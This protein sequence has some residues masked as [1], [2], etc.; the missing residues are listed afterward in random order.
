MAFAA[1][2][3]RAQLDLTVSKTHSPATFPRGG[4]GTYTIVVSNGSPGLPTSADIT[5]IDTLPLGLTPAGASGNGWTCS[6]GQVVTCTTSQVV[7]GGANAPPISLTVNVS[8]GILT[9]S[10]VNTVTVLGGG[11]LPAQAGNNVG[12]DNTPIS[13]AVTITTTSLPPATVG[14]AYSQALVAE[15]GRTPYTWSLASGSLGNLMLQPNGTIS[16]T[17]SGTGTLNFTVRVTDN[18]GSTDEQA[19]SIS[20]NPSELRIA[21]SSPLA[22]AALGSPYQQTFAASGGT[23][24]YGSWT[25][26]SGRL[27]N[28]LTLNAGSGVLSGT[29][30]APGDYSFAVTVRDNAARTA[31]KVFQLAVPP[32]GSRLTVL[33]T[34]CPPAPINVDYACSLQA[35]GGVPGYTWSLG[36]GGL[37]AGLSLDPEAGA[38]RGTPTSIG[39]FEI[40]IIVRDSVAATDSETVTIAVTN[41][42]SATLTVSGDTAPGG[43]VLVALVLSR[44]FPQSV[45]GEIGLTFT[46]HA[47]LPGDMDD[48]A[49][50]FSTGGRTT[51]FTVPPGETQARFNGG[52]LMLQLGTVAGTIRLTL[53]EMRTG[54]SN[55]TPSP[56]LARDIVINRLAPV[57]REVRITNR[58]ASGFTVEVAGFATSREITQAQFQFNGAP[59]Q[60]LVAGQATIPLN[61]PAQIWY[62]GQSSRQF[63][64][65]FVYTQPFTVEGNVSAIASLAVTLS[66]TV[67]NS[68]SGSGSF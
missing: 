19:L 23:P 44:V 22:Q 51:R 52:S 65:Q 7:A 29:P 59:G 61:Q 6:G 67:G 27:P 39:N 56:A 21:T 43:Q 11:E 5:V 41:D 62:Q 12:V 55:I 42:A 53:T 36:Q 8:P 14:V 45:T 46:P 17:P 13:A 37:P 18:A 64:S 9:S 50:Q 25:V 40:E 30:T 24:P 47:T 66:N 16:G 1:T 54:S 15:G 4:T 33:T 68:A 58:T 10:V 38:I 63:G 31:S 57:I 48:P 32:P 3:L 2:P 34:S 35:S 20:I 49:I 28:G 60:T 26:T